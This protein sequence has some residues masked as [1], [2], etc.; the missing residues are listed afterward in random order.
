MSITATIILGLCITFIIMYTALNIDKLKPKKRHEHQDLIDS[1]Q[2]KIAKA[3]G[4]SM[5]Q[6]SLENFSAETKTKDIYENADFI[7]KNCTNLED[8]IINDQINEF[9]LMKLADLN[10]IQLQIQSGWYAVVIELLKELH[11]NGWNKKV[12]CIKEKYAGLRFH[13]DCEYE[14]L[15]YNI[16][17]KYEHKATNTCETC[18][19]PGQTRYNTNWDYAACR[20]HYLENRGKIT[21]EE[22]GFNYNGNFY[23]WKDIREASFEDL[24]NDKYIFLNIEFHKTKIRHQGWEDQKMYVSRYTIGFGNFLSSIPP[25]IKNLNYKYI[26]NFK[27]VDYCEICGY[28]A[29]YFGA[30]EC[31]ENEDWSSYQKSWNVKEDEIDESKRDHIYHKQLRWARHKD[32]IYESRQN[33]YPKN[34]DLKIVYTDKQLKEYLKNYE[35]D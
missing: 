23:Q 5:E 4:A 27:N 2:S 30:C 19:E 28:K 25:S 8:F 11:A 13:T 1:I 20:K 34:P 16:T 3:N 26:K 10:G 21:V 35:R 18:G 29:V 15:L 7:N 22:S 9:D 32:D 14:S 24:H 33:N 6:F 17:E 12:S 31:C